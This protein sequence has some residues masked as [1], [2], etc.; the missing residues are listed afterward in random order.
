MKCSTHALSPFCEQNSSTWFVQRSSV[1]FGLSPLGEART[2]VFVGN[3]SLAS[4]NSVVPAICHLLL[5]DNPDVNHRALLPLS[6]E[7][8][9]PRCSCFIL[10]AGIRVY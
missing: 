1:S 4:Y 5:I 10:S 7:L 8:I 9:V 2:S 3:W 6:P